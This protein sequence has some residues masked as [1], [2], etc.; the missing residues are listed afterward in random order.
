[1]SINILTF[2]L[3]ATSTK[4][5]FYT[6]NKEIFKE[7][8]NH[9]KSETQQFETERDQKDYRVNGVKKILSKHD[10]SMTSID[11]IAA[12]AGVLPPVEAGAVE[13]TPEMRDYHEAYDLV[14]HISLISS[15]MALELA[16]EAGPD[17]KAYVYDSDSIDQLNPIAKISGSKQLPRTSLGHFQNIRGA[18]REVSKDANLDLNDSNYV[19][20]HIGSGNTIAAIENNRIIDLV[21]EDEGPFSSERAG[22]LATKHLIDLCYEKPKAEVQKMLRQ[23]GGLYSYLET[24]DGRKIEKMIADGDEYAELVY[25]ALAFQIAKAIAEMQVSLAGKVDRIVVT[26]GLAHSVMVTDWIKKWTHHIAEVVV[27]PGEFELEVLSQG[28]YRV[29]TGEEESIKINF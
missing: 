7:T 27:Y 20:A 14:D 29:L 3:G 12:K 11:G 28:V 10:V 22:G 8:I 9:P 25:E 15:T 2:S 6:D 18:A 4:V 21:A 16:E 26:G 1:M 5:S 23:E 19:I 13:M 24:N 17:V